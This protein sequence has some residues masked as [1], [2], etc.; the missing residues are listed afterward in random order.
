MKGARDAHPARWKRALTFVAIVWALAASFAAF[1]LLSMRGFDLLL[2]FPQVFGNLLLS[3]ATRDS[4]ACE[5]QPGENPGRAA[6]ALNESDARVGSWFLGV[7]VGRDAQAR[8]S[9]TVD[10]K[11]LDASAAGVQQVAGLLGT[12][13]PGL[14]VPQQ[15]PLASTEFVAFIEGDQQGTA[16]QLAVA[17]APLACQVYKLGALWGYSTLTRFALPGERSIFGVE[18]RHYARKVGLPETLWRPMIE[19]TRRDA[20]P[21]EINSQSTMLT[22]GVTK[23]LGSR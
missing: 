19:R 8:Q 4:K 1:E 16:H 21:A 11:V 23:F 20:T 14:F 7:R 3:R 6:S 9:T 2:S 15:K 22:D 17:Y 10:A 13:A 12:P 18:I 5:V